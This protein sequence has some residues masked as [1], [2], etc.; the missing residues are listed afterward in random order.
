MTSVDMREI[1]RRTAEAMSEQVFM[2]TKPVSNHEITVHVRNED[3]GEL[4]TEMHNSYPFW[5]GAEA[6]QDHA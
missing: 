3:N 2:S 6:M 5:G 1:E 4:E